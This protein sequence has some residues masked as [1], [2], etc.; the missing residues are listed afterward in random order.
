VLTLLYI[1]SEELRELVEGSQAKITHVAVT[2]AFKYA[3]KHGE[4]V[5]ISSSPPC[6]NYMMS[7]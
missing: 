4:Q 5:I 1:D 7:L 6:P 3:K 2:M